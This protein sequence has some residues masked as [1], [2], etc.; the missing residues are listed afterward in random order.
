MSIIR[1]QLDKNT[2][3][4][5]KVRYIA[6][7]IL[8]KYLEDKKN[9]K[10][11]RVVVG[12]HKQDVDE[13]IDLVAKYPDGRHDEGFAYRAYPLGT[14]KNGEIDWPYGN[15]YPLNLVNCFG[16]NKEDKDEDKK[17]YERAMNCTCEAWKIVNGYG[18]LAIMI[19][20]DKDDNPVSYQIYD[21][22]NMQEYLRDGAEENINDPKKT[23]PDKNGDG[24]F[25]IIKMQDIEKYIYD[26]YRTKHYSNADD[27]ITAPEPL[28]EELIKEFIATGN[29]IAAFEN[30]IKELADKEL[31]EKPI[32]LLD[33]KID[34]ETLSEYNGL[35]NTMDELGII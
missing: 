17:P 7:I 10:G 2:E 23:K 14:F 3:K 32:V 18:R 13:N 24:L 8:R 22:R 4:S 1:K 12:T 5:N 11:I 25:H 6:Q 35:I 19:R 31:K 29:G 28:C 27:E 15:D 33:E 30:Y 26:K 34:E 20:C 16:G 21:Q 9:I